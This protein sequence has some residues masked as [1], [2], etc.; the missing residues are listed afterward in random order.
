MCEGKIEI[1]SNNNNNFL[2]KTKNKMK[3]LL[4]SMFAMAIALTSCEKSALQV[5]DNG[6]AGDVATI[7]INAA[8]ESTTRSLADASDATPTYY[9]EVYKDGV[10]YLDLGSNTTG[11]FSVRLVTNQ[12]FDLV[13]WADYAEGYFNT[14]ALTA[15]TLTDAGLKAINSTE[16]DGFAGTQ[17][18]N[19]DNNATIPMV[20]TRPLAR[21]N[22]ATNDIADIQFDYLKPTHVELTYKS[23]LYTTY[24]VLGE[25]IDA[26]VA[27]GV[28]TNTTAVIDENGSISADYLM[29]P[30]EGCL[31]DFTA[32]FYNG[33]DIITYY[34]FNSIPIK[35]NFQTNISGNLLTKTGDITVTFE[36]GW[37]TPDVEVEAILASNP[38][39]ATAQI[40]EAIANNVNTDELS[41]TIGGTKGGTVELP[42]TDVTITLVF[43]EEQT[44]DVSVYSEGFTGMANI[45]LVG[46]QLNVYIPNGD[47]TLMS[48][49]SITG[50]GTATKPNTFTVA[51]GADV[52][53][54]T[55]NAGNV[56]IYGEVDE[57]VKGEDNDEDTVVT[58]Y[59]NASTPTPGDGISITEITTG[60][61]VLNDKN[62]ETIAAAYAVAVDG[63]VI[64]LGAYTFD[65]CIVDVKNSTKSIT[66]S[67]VAG[68]T[69]VKSVNI[70][71]NT[72]IE[73]NNIEFF[74]LSTYSAGSTL[75]VMSSASAT[76]NNCSVNLTETPTMSSY[77]LVES[78]YNYGASLIFNGCT[79]QDNG[80]SA[81]SNLYLNPLKEGGVTE[82]NNCTFVDCSVSADIT[83]AGDT[84][85]Y[86]VIS[87][88]NFGDSPFCT[89]D[90]KLSINELDVDTKLFFNDV[91]NNNTF[92][93]ENKI[94]VTKLPYAD[95]QGDAYYVNDL[96]FTITGGI[97]S[98]W[99]SSAS[100]LAELYPEYKGYPV[101]VLKLEAS[102]DILTFKKMGGQAGYFANKTDEQVANLVAGQSAYEVNEENSTII[103]YGYGWGTTLSH[104]IVG[105]DAQGNYA[106]PI[107]QFITLDKDD[108]FNTSTTKNNDTDTQIQISSN[109]DWQIY[110]DTTSIGDLQGDY[111]FQLNNGSQSEDVEILLNDFIIEPNQQYLIARGK[112]CT[113][114]ISLNAKYSL[115][116]NTDNYFK[117]GTTQNY[118]TYRIEKW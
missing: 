39:D 40:A 8:T 70:N 34:D 51:L 91:I 30:N 64:E 105:Y 89:G 77:R 95:Y 84:Y 17:V 2:T 50:L 7:S 82:V 85:Y 38:D 36:E 90:F 29:L 65:E 67:G 61:I 115:K 69:K 63:D 92:T 35:V 15:V 48:G 114:N 53:K 103:I 27:T 59:D 16:L 80:L 118:L 6:V 101:M 52:E 98:V 14:E 12:D 106:T 66:I 32:T 3:K 110:L 94:K 104:A 4:F 62:Y 44:G 88:N 22:V 57:I 41:V 55:V 78:S 100:P 37:Y 13:A 74:G 47:G 31:V 68:A 5:D 21:I 45:K 113:E 54:I 19:L 97:M 42:T 79:F 109:T 20:L 107:V 56:D 26:T 23:D 72:N 117:E 96:L 18:V 111:Y 9:L 46:Q 76:F 33:S 108:V 81:S 43:L 1:N 11:E 49:S 75:S 83:V 58:V 10:L 71:F 28:E 25:S 99:D 87:G 93:G 73:F 60:A 112:Q 24:N 102:E 116:N 86:P